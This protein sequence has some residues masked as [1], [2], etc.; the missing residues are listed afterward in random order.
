MQKKHKKQ[1]TKKTKQTKTKKQNNDTKIN[2]MLLQSKANLNEI[3][4]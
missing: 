3:I 1:K 2:V 4:F